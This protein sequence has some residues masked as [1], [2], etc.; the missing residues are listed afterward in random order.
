M[1]RH[2]YS[3]ATWQNQEGNAQSVRGELGTQG[4]VIAIQGGSFHALMPRINGKTQNAGLGIKLSEK[5]WQ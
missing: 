5:Y 2:I 4:G 3:R 1:Y